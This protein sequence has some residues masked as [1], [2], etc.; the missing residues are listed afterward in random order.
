MRFV[1]GEPELNFFV[2]SYQKQNNGTPFTDL[3]DAKQ[4]ECY[5]E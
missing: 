3:L 4:L 5:V 1:V 2:E